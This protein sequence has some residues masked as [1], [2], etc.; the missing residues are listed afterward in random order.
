[1][2]KNNV[3]K[4]ITAII[5]LISIS[6]LSPLLTTTNA[7]TLS[8]NSSSIS[9]SIT[10]TKIINAKTYKLNVTGASDT[11]SAFQKMINS[12]P[13][14]TSI[15]LPRGKYK[16]SNTI[17]LKNGMKLI[18]SNDVV[19]IG[20]GKNTLFS[21]GNS[22]SFQGIEFQN[23]ATALSVFQKKGLNVMSCRFTNN[24]HYAAI[25]FYGASSS[26]VTN[27]YFYDIHK[28]GILID[29]NSSNVI[30]SKN[31]FN[32]AKV[33][34]GYRYAQIS[35]HV[36]CLSGTKIYVTNNIIKNSGGQGIIFSY[37]SATKKGTTHSVASN[38][39]CISNGQE[40]IT[41]YGGN[42]KLS[43]F[44]TITNNTCGK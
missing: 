35:G 20:T 10:S 27:S 17:R 38:N 31:N 43:S 9:K 12:F 15:K 4:T 18:A 13:S 24:I 34:A 3:K 11:A 37:N 8:T 7:T 16:F 42:K 6:S 29:N 23:C 5:L 30:I 40:G 28:Y 36:Y 21:T 33:F 1:M 22:N 41:T 2:L 39:Q 14:G 44:N 19:I 26:S 32:N 25:N